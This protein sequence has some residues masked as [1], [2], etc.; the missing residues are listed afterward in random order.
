MSLNVLVTGYLL[1]GKQM[2]VM[3]ML[4]VAHRE[5][6]RVESDMITSVQIIDDTFVLC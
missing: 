1:N 6:C 5:D 4:C 2:Q 3:Q